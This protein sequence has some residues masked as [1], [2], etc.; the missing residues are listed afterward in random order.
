M[1]YAQANLTNALLAVIAFCVA[2]FLVQDWYY[3][4]RAW[5]QRRKTEHEATEQAYEAQKNWE[6]K[7]AMSPHYGLTPVCSIC[8]ARACV[9]ITGREARCSNCS[10]LPPTNRKD[11]A[12]E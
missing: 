7:V 10:T 4:I 12:A 1:T 8:G 11:A 5:A 6:R 9:E 2:T 3:T